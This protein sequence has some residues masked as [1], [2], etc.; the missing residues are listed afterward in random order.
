MASN[1]TNKKDE[2]LGKLDKNDITKPGLCSIFEQCAFSFERMQA[3]GWTA[4]MP[5]AF[6]KVYGDSKE[7]LS[8]FITYNMEFMNTELHM[9]TLLQSMVIAMEEQGQ[10]RKLI[11]GVRNG[12]FGPFAGIGD[13]IFWFVVL[14]ITAGIACSLSKRGFVFGPIVFILAYLLVGFS[15]ILLARL[16]Y[17]IGA[18]A[19]GRLG[20]A[21]KYATK[22]AGIL[23][24]TVVGALIPSYVSIAFSED[25][26]FGVGGATVQ[27]AFDNLLPNVLPLA[28]TFSV[29]WLFKKRHHA[30]VLFVILGVMVFGIIMLGLGWM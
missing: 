14:P 7:D 24:T 13:S 23:G 19:L 28:V 10:N 15:C 18:S 29:Y 8:E 21:T 20:D 5:P 26:V 4:N 6:K 3:P 22:A 12:L 17:N 16:G 30:D 27:S 9:A 11:G 25:L 1:P 2:P